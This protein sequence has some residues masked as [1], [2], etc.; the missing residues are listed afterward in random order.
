MNKIVINEKLHTIDFDNS[1]YKKWHVGF[2]NQFN[3][4]V[5]NNYTMSKFCGDFRVFR[6]GQKSGR[7]QIRTGKSRESISAYCRFLRETYGAKIAI[8]DKSGKNPVLLDSAGTVT[9]KILQHADIC[10]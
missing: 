2:M 9:T 8:Y 5:S 7:I 4:A 1:E 3:S 6:L 10:G